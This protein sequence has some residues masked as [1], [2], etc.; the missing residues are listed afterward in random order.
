MDTFPESALRASNAPPTWD[1][2]SYAAS[3]PTSSFANR[4]HKPYKPKG[5]TMSQAR[6]NHA[7]SASHPA[8]TNPSRYWLGTYYPTPEEQQDY[9]TTANLPELR[10]V[11]DGGDIT[12]FRG[13]WEMGGKGD[14][15][16]K[17]HVQFAVCFPAKCRAPQ[18]RSILGGKWGMFTGWLDVA[19][20]A[21]VWDY[22]KKEETRVADIPDWGELT[23]ESGTRVDLDYVYAE[24]AKGVPIYEIAEQFPRQ[25]MRN[26]AAISKL[27]AMYDKPRPYGD[28]HVEI[29]WGVTGSGKSHKAYHEYPDAYRKSIPGKWWEGYKGQETVIFE[30]FNPQEDKELRLPELLKILD[31]YPY[32]VEIKGASMQLKA[33]RFIFTSNINPATWYSGHPQVPAF[34]RRINKVVNFA[35]D[36]EQQDLLQVTGQLES[37][38]LRSIQCACA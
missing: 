34:C 29:W 26:H 1:S 22:V 10:M 5:S 20:S 14:K 33:N 28:I 30:E 15:A 37:A 24:I 3:R 25:F 23:D 38:G 31:K 21:A 4:Q 11:I 8:A 13:Q 36:R 32:Q 12:C 17:L 27:C 9:T 2:S 19:R 18:A 7:A 16:G 6:G 35:L